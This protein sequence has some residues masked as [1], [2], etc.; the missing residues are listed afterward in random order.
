[1]NVR[2]GG[3]RLELPRF[4]LWFGILLAYATLGNVVGVFNIGFTVI[5]TEGNLAGRVYGAFGH[6]NETAALIVCLLPAYIATAQSGR[7]ITALLWVLAGLT[8]GTL[9]IL[10]GSR[11]ALVSLALATIL[12]SYL[13]AT[14]S[15]GVAPRLS[16]QDR[17]ACHKGRADDVREP[18]HGE[19]IRQSVY[20]ALC[21]AVLQRKRSRR[22]DIHALVKT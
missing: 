4:H 8:S 14:S 18:R 20:F 1:M 6:A 2:D 7:R 16:R 5:G 10:T 22:A 11:G 19:S 9:L 12:G 3:I 21:R 15:H 13:C 17:D